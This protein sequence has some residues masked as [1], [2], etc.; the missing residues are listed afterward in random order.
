MVSMTRILLN[1]SAMTKPLTESEQADYEERA[2]ILEFEAGNTR[3]EAERLALA[4]VLDYRTRVPKGQR[5]E[6]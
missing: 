3:D 6:A 5:G 4:M 2:A 1:V